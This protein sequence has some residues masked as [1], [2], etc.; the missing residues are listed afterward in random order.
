MTQLIDWH[1]HI[2]PAELVEA[3]EARD[4]PPLVAPAADGGR[5]LV[6]RKNAQ[7]LSSAPSL[8]SADLRIAELDAA[9]IDVQVLSVPGM[10]GIDTAPR[11]VEVPEDLAA[12]L[13]AAGLRE[14]FDELAPSHR[15]EH[16]RAILDAK[17]PE[18]RE[19]RIAAAIAKLTA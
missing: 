12:A 6:T 17:K 10:M 11:E 14:A 15:R 4:A 2:L 3:L 8:F 9:G 13:A 7:A 5:G 19:R 18:T 1:A 16:V